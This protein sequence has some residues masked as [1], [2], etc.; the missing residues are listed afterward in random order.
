MSKEFAKVLESQLIKNPKYSSGWIENASKI[1]A[2]SDTFIE[3]ELAK[4]DAE[5]LDVINAALDYNEKNKDD[6]VNVDAIANPELNATQMRLMFAGMQNKLSVSLLKKLIS[7]NI[8]YAVS[9]YIVQAAIDGQDLSKY[10]SGY[11][12]DQVYEIYAGIHNGVDVS[13]YDDPHISAGMMGLMRHALELG[14]SASLDFNTSV[15][16]IK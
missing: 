15:L 14:L 2:N 12:P 8:P 5:Q 9:N 7:K 13:V 1:I 3:E 10:I 11:E 6:G 16:T 4:F